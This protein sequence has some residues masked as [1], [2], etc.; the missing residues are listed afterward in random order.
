MSAD[1]HQLT[2]APY[3]SL[4]QVVVDAK[5]HAAHNFDYRHLKEPDLLWTGAILANYA[6]KDHQEHELKDRDFLLNSSIGLG[7]YDNK[8]RI[9][10]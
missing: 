6:Q 5:H 7:L 9:S 3:P 4:S 10:Q 8:V 2:R 1:L